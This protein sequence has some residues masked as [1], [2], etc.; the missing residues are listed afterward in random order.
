MPNFVSSQT[1]AWPW[2]FCVDTWPCACL[3]HYVLG[4]GL[5]LS[6][7]ILGLVLALSI[8]CLVLALDLLC[9]YLALCLP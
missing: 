6:V 1:T 5:G 4:L 9:G 2:T 7:W 8:M 3:E